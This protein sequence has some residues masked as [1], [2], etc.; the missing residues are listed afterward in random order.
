MIYRSGRAL[1]PLELILETGA[2]VKKVAWD[3]SSSFLWKRQTN[4][5]KWYVYVRWCRT[6]SLQK[7]F[8]TIVFFSSRWAAKSNWFIELTCF[9]NFCMNNAC[10]SEL[11]S[12]NDLVSVHSYLINQKTIHICRHFSPWIAAT[13]VPF[14]IRQSW[15]MNQF[16]SE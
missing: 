4:Y 12:K 13:P 10:C 8:T 11:F 3:S 5:C 7:V 2:W 16:P 15:S 1:F 9:L 6:K 14:R